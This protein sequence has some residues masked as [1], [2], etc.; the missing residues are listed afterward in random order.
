MSNLTIGNYYT[1]HFEDFW[2]IVKVVDFTRIKIV[3]SPQDSK[4]WPEK[5]N[6]WRRWPHPD[7]NYFIETFKDYEL[8]NKEDVIIDLL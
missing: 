6:T 5:I 3:A 4:L 7:N 8:I 2:Y 1:V